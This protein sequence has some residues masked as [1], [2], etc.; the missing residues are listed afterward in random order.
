[1]GWMT[2][3][4]LGQPGYI[5]E[6]NEHCITLA[7]ALKPAGYRCYASGK[8]H[9]VFDKYMEPDSPK[10]NWPLQR[11]FDRYY[12]GLAGDGGYYKP[13]RLTQDNT[14]IEAPDEDYYYTDAI[15]DHAVEFLTDHYSNAG[16]EPFFMYV[17]YY[18]PHRPLHAKPEDIAKYRGS[19]MVGWDEIRKRRYQ[20]QT[21]M[22][23][24]DGSWDLSPGT[25][26]FRHGRTCR[27][28]RSRCGTC[29]WPPTRR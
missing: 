9:V 2:V 24:L 10:D 13:S 23:L 14:R 8:W 26:P 5:G 19:Y 11:G 15:T 12:G 25:T 29:E 4:D 17:P 6:L 1:M 16:D 18:A 7:Q 27:R 28:T 3:S 20:K 21:E 22:G